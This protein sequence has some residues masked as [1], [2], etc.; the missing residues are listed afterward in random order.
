[1]SPRPWLQHS[2]S[3]LSSETSETETFSRK[4]TW[5]EG[6]DLTLASAFEGEIKT[7]LKTLEAEL[8]Q[9]MQQIRLLE[10]NVQTLTAQLHAQVCV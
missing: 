4:F 1:M 7:R 5:T 6:G 9:R 3:P 8:V 10:E 2:P